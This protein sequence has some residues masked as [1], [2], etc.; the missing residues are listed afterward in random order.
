LNYDLQ[1]H[2]TA[3]SNASFWT[4]PRNVELSRRVNSCSLS[5]LNEIYSL[6]AKNKADAA[7]RILYDSGFSYDG[8]LPAGA[9][10]GDPQ[11]TSFHGMSGSIT[12]HSVM[13]S[14]LEQDV[15]KRGYDCTGHRYGNLYM[16]T[17]AG[18]KKAKAA[19]DIAYGGCFPSHPREAWFAIE[20]IMHDAYDAYLKQYGCTNR[21]FT[22][23]MYP[24]IPPPLPN[25]VK[26]RGFILRARKA[27][28][29]STLSWL[30]GRN[31]E[32]NELSFDNAEH[33]IC[34]VMSRFGYTP[35]EVAAM[36]SILIEQEKKKKTHAVVD[37]A[38]VAGSDTPG[39][40]LFGCFVLFA[41][42]ALVLGALFFIACM[43]KCFGAAGNVIGI[44]MLLG[45]LGFL[46]VLC[47]VFRGKKGRPP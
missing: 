17:L 15:K 42:M 32:P 27:C 22:H 20:Q 2:Y 11:F 7:R 12:R 46:I 23:P 5:R 34:S 38:G 33:L 6:N 16:Q 29:I 37:R 19:L 35:A 39:S 4:R 10:E 18:N 25:P 30:L 47:K 3:Q 40:F 21:L 26:L 43:M 24:A 45:V 31:M 36:K 41:A 9:L 44:G 8:P 13:T 14:Y 28:D 1:Q